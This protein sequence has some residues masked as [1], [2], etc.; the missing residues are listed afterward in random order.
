MTISA[1]VPDRDQLNPSLAER[2]T[3][4][5]SSKHPFVVDSFALLDHRTRELTIP[6]VGAPPGRYLSFEHGK[7]TLMIM[8]ERPI[9]HIGRGLIADVRLEDSH[10]SR[11]HAILALRGEG[12]RVLDDRSSNG[13]YVNGRSVTVAPLTDGDVLRFGRAVFRYTEIALRGRTRPLRQIPL[14]RDAGRREPAD[15]AA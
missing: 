6:A 13:T 11:R 2:P 7:A 1:Q 5:L 4:G 15:A 3:H 14:A 9:T 12:A 10:V 8:L